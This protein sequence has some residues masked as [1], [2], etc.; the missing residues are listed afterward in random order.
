M[1]YC[2]MKGSNIPD[3]WCYELMLL[4]LSDFMHV[5]KFMWYVPQRFDAYDRMGI[6]MYLN[7]LLRKV[8]RI[9]SDS[10]CA[11]SPPA[12]SSYLLTCLGTLI[13]EEEVVTLC[14][15]GEIVGDGMWWSQIRG[16]LVLGLC[17]WFEG[18]VG[19]DMDIHGF[20][21]MVIHRDRWGKSLFVWLDGWD[22]NRMSHFSI[23]LVG[24]G[25]QAGYGMSHVGS[26][27]YLFIFT[28]HNHVRYCF[29]DLIVTNTMVQSYDK[30]H[31]RLARWKPFEDC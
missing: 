9:L 18:K 31:K 21:D 19:W 22:F 2:T 29:V 3:V 24:Q 14:L 20:W 12:M 30:L 16:C 1:Y 8:W 11:P 13:G 15:V 26:T 25:C 17:F 6:C 28:K 7:I 23:S 5:I 27:L 10:H 4:V